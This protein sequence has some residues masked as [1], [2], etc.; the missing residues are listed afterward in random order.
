[1][2]KSTVAR[3]AHRLAGAL[4]G[5]GRL[6]EGHFPAGRVDHED[7]GA[8]RRAGGQ[9]DAALGVD[10]HPVAPLLVAEVDERPPRTVDEPVGAEREGVDLHR[11]LL[12]RRSGRVDPVGAVV[13]VGDVK[14]LLVGAD[15]DAVGLLDVVG[16]LDDVPSV[17]IR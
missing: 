5:L 16:D 14:R 10:G 12:G 15:R 17:S 6:D 13:V 9:V 8:A 4:L 1:M 2:P 11:A 3:I 7:S